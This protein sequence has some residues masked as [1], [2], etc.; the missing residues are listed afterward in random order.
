M[1]ALRSLQHFIWREGSIGFQEGIADSRLLPCLN[2][3]FHGN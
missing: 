2:L 3:S 1:T